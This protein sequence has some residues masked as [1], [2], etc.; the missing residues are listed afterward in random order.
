VPSYLA[1]QLREL[2][3]RECSS[4]SATTRRLIA[5]GVTRELKPRET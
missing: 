1:A 3:D 5:I 2:A 4:L